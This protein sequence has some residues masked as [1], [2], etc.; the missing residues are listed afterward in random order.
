MTYLQGLADAEDGGETAL[1]G[2][3][4]LAGDEL[5]EEEEKNEWAVVCSEWVRDGM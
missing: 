5:E 3:L 2:G 1:N 4:D